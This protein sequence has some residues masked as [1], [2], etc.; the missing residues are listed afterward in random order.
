MNE[1]M[2][3]YFRMG[4]VHFMSY[5]DVLQDEMQII[6]TLK[7][8]IGD[9][10][11]SVVE[12]APIA[13]KKIRNQVKELFTHSDCTLVYTA[14][15]K[16]LGGKLNLN[17]EDEGQRQKAIAQVK[18]YIDEAIEVG[19]E[20]I[21]IIAGQYRSEKYEEAFQAFVNSCKELC[22]YAK[23]ALGFQ[24]EVEQFDYDFHNKLLIGSSETAKRLAE[25]M[26][27]YSNFG[28]LV[29]LSHLPLIHETPQECL[30]KLAGY[31]THVHIGNAVCSHPDDYLYGDFHPRFSLENSA[32]GVGEV[33]DFFKSLFKIGFFT[34]NMPI[35]SF[36]IKAWPG[37][38]PDLVLAECKR[39][40]NL[41]WS[42]LEKE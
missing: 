39:M 24:V 13:D 19:A 31:V 4:T 14:A 2:N 7:K 27:S 38:E 29:D 17:S 9:P 26:S 11:F 16:S 22:E 42:L 37:D 6:P 3:K 5:P 8:I 33:V 41:S 21:G 32:I 12:M 40:M 35:V 28:I 23:K 30:E 18:E 20:G 36:E 34:K 15:P 25:E 1:G 10:F